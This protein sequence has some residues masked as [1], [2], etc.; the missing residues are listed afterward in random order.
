M[1]CV[2]STRGAVLAPGLMMNRV[3][4]VFRRGSDPTGKAFDKIWDAV[5]GD[6]PVLVGMTISD[7]F[8]KPGTDGVID[9]DEPQDL[10]RRHAVI[11]VATGTQAKRRLLLVRNSWGDSWGLSGYAWLVERY[12]SPRIRVALAIK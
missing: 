1:H 7:A 6:Q 5:E 8:Y 4:R 11:A 10:A 9:S 2:Q 12:A 3:Y